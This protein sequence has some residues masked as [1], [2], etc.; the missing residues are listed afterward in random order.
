MLT[1]KVLVFTIFTTFLINFHFSQNLIL[2]GSFEN[3]DECPYVS[4]GA[5]N[6]CIGWKNT[7]IYL[8]PDYFHSCSNNMPNMGGFRFQYPYEGNAFVGIYNFKNEHLN[9]QTDNVREYITTELISS[10]EI[11]NCYLLTMYVNLSNNSFFCSN[12]IGC[13]LSDDT[14]GF[15]NLTLYNFKPQLNYNK[16]ICDTL[17]W[18]KICGIFKSIENEKYLTIGNFY[19]DS[20][21]R[22][23]NFNE[24]ELFQMKASYFH[25]DDISLIPINTDTMLAQAGLDTN[26]MYGDSVFIGQE[27]TNLDCKWT[28][29]NTGEMLADSISGIW[30]QPTENTTY[31]VEQ[32]LCGTISYDTVTV[33]V[34]GVGLQESNFSPFG[35]GQGGGFFKII[36]NPNNGSFTIQT[37]ALEIQELTLYDAQARKL[38]NLDKNSTKMDL[39]LPKGVYFLEIISENSRNLEKVVVN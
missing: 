24:S 38:Y 22:V 32:N 15:N 29:L 25:I 5:I 10:L 21:I 17:N 8:T 3:Y 19:N 13:Y 1:K 12:N 35:G 14:L 27:I 30:V 33:F 31:L 39:N 36:P 28:N 26:I 23:I 9:A 16:F 6:K 2:N 37:N 34:G 7:Y 11:G 20:L 4:S 18:I